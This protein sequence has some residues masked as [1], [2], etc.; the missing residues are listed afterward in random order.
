MVDGDRRDAGAERRAEVALVDRI[1]VAVPVQLQ[2][3]ARRLVPQRRVVGRPDQ[4][5]L[6]QLAQRPVELHRLVGIEGV[7]APAAPV[8]QV[9][10][11][12]RL[13]PVAQLEGLDLEAIDQPYPQQDALEQRHALSRRLEVTADVLR[14]DPA[15][16]RALEDEPH[17]R[18]QVELLRRHAEDDAAR[19]GW[20]VAHGAG[21][22]ER[23][24]ESDLLDAEAPPPR[25]ANRQIVAGLED[26]SGRGIAAGQALAAH[27]RQRL[28]HHV[29]RQRAADRLQERT[30]G[31]AADRSVLEVFDDVLV[32]DRLI[33]RQRAGNPEEHD[34]RRDEDDRQDQ[35]FDAL[36]PRNDA[37]LRQHPGSWPPGSI[38]ASHE[39]RRVEHRHDLGNHRV[40]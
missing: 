9:V 11:E 22:A 10:A 24:V 12:R 2:A 27:R 39:R 29:R 21:V 18:L 38:A 33:A 37:R 19:R 32:D 35:I 40:A 1:V 8:G 30:A 28:E 25:Y 15:V 26:Q 13:H 5:R 3:L 17:H 6:R 20:R 34:P 16:E 7:D 36:A 14:R 31:L 4:L 23:A